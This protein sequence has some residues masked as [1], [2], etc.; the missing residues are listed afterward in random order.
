MRLPSLKQILRRAP[1]APDVAG[2]GAAVLAQFSNLAGT[3]LKR[4][5]Q[6][7]HESGDRRNPDTL[8]GALLSEEQRQFCLHIG[9]Q[10]LADLRKEAY[11][12][13]LIARTKVYDQMLLDAV[14]SG[15][16]RVLIMGTGFDTR[17]YRFGGH[18][19]ALNVQVAECDQPEAIAMKRQLAASLP[20]AGHVRYM[21]VDLNQPETWTDVSQWL[22]A[23]DAP[24]LLIAEGVSPYIEAASFRTLL[25]GLPKLLPPCSRIGYDFKLSGVADEFG[26]AASVVPRFRLNL[27]ERMIAEMH[28]PWGYRQTSVMASDAMMQA[29]VPSWNASVSPLFREDA[30]VQL[31]C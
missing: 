24:A 15:V 5:I 13:Y 27:D 7:L 21:P 25:A 29:Q 2:Q 30:V 22:G 18:L 28:A 10:G 6:S 14:A 20:F 4:H 1:T 16:R 31:V 11:Y 23:A 3:A 26:K 9:Q 19:A 8:A 17:F 12:F